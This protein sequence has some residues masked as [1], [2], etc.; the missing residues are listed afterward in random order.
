M[1]YVRPAFDIHKLYVLPT[2]R[3]YVSFVR[4][5]EQTATIALY[6]IKWLVFITEMQR[7]YC[8][9][10][11]EFLQMC[12]VHLSVSRLWQAPYRRLVEL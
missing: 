8:A 11:I 4:I 9:V 1:L 5:T 3:M 7:V 12:L 2:Q 6:S 10:R